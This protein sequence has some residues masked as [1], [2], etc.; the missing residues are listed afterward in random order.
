MQVVHELT[1]ATQPLQLTS[2]ILGNSE[3]QQAAAE[4]MAGVANLLV[5]STGRW[6]AVTSS[7]HVHIFDLESMAYQGHL[8]PLKASFV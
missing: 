3:A 6:A 8:P 4:Q 2:H 5:S 1:A 7:C